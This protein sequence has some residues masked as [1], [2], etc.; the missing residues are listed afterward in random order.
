MPGDED[1]RNVNVY[2]SELALQIE[3]TQSRHSHVE[4]QTSRNIRSRALQQLLRRSKCLNPKSHRSHE[5][6]QRLAYPFII[7]DDEHHLIVH[8]ALS[9][10]TGQ[11]NR[12]TA[13][14]GGFEVAQRRPP[15]ASMMVRLIASPM[16]IPSGLVVK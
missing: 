5:T 10:C 6:L 2:L 8:G 15:C 14:F 4:Y 3:T 16:P 9:G 7:I 13:P 1:D 11:V 12:K